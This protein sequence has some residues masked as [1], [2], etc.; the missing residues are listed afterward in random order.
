MGRRVHVSC[1]FIQSSFHYTL[2]LHKSGIATQLTKLAKRYYHRCPFRR[3]N[4]HSILILSSHAASLKSLSSERHPRGESTSPCSC[5]G[6]SPS[7]LRPL[8]EER[9]SF[10]VGSH[11]LR[12]SCQGEVPAQHPWKPLGLLSVGGGLQYFLR[13]VGCSPGS[14]ACESS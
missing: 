4:C 8:G 6:P 14:L 13:A 1:L 7:F 3:Q 11:S 2:R 10:S 9:F 5:H 12:E